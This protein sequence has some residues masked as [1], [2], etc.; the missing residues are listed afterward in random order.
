MLSSGIRN[1]NNLQM[2]LLVLV[3]DRTYSCTKSE[4]M[5]NIVFHLEFYPLSNVDLNPPIAYR[6]V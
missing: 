6:D 3:C 5:N 4:K 2:Q 1:V